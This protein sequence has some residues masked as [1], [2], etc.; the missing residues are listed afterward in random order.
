MLGN[1]GFCLKYFFVF[2]IITWVRLV[3][4]FKVFLRYLC[5][6]VLRMDIY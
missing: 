2:N 4:C 6:V 3:I 1:W 5:I